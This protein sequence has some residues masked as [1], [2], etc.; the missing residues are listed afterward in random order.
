MH[1][2]AADTVAHWSRQWTYNQMILFDC[3]S[4][5]SGSSMHLAKT[6]PVLQKN[7]NKFYSLWHT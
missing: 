3:R 4:V 5:I 6:A 7:P 1:C 2:E